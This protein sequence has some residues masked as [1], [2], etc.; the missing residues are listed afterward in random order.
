[1]TM[2]MWTGHSIFILAPTLHVLITDDL[3]KS[4]RHL[5]PTNVDFNKKH[6]T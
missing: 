2:E 5:R 3:R 4:I 1:M 6:V